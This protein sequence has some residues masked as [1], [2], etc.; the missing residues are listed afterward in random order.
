MGQERVFQGDGSVLKL[1]YNGDFTT[2]CIYPN[3]S[4]YTLKMGGF[5]VMSSVPQ[6]NAKKK[7]HKDKREPWI[8]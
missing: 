3:S 7:I 6:K 8:T 2:V 1:F 4:S 5:C